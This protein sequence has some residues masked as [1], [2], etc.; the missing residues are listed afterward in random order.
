M[1]P[2]PV[3]L[4]LSESVFLL[5]VTVIQDVEM[6]NIP[7]CKALSLPVMSSGCVTLDYL[8][9]GVRIRL[10]LPLSLPNANVWTRLKYHTSTRG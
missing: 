8:G 3:Y 4:S 6:P 9:K 7:R 10:L 5:T 1:Q 2:S